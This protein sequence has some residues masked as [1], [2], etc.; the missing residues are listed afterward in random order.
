MK[1]AMKLNIKIALLVIVVVFISI[2]II[3]SF[4]VPWMTSNIESKEAINIMNVAKMTA[5]SE[6]V[7][8]ALKEKDVN[9]KIENYIKD[10]I[11]CLEQVE[12]IIVADNSGIRYSHPNHKS[13]GYKFAV[14]MKRG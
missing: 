11:N 1:R 6:E 2:L 7:V 4:A 14:E 3:I 8:Y 12:Y 9:G 13:I 10:Q 5:N